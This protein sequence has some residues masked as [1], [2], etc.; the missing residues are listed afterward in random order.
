MGW[1]LKWD[2]ERLLQKVPLQPRISH[3][4][5][6]AYGECIVAFKITYDTG[7]IQ[8]YLYWSRSHFSKLSVDINS[9]AVCTY[10]SLLPLHLFQR[11]NSLR[12]PLRHRHNQRSRIRRHHPWEDSRVNN[13]Q[14]IRPVHLCVQ[15]NDCGAA[16]L[17]SVVLA[18][19]CAAHPV[20]GAA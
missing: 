4:D 7:Q 14:V 16:L 17:S 10:T 2:G 13:K 1:P 6:A 3:H 5:R 11:Q 8:K 20:I 15:V 19:L 9:N 18:Y 12:R